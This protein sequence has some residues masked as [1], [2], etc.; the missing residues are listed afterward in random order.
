MGEPNKFKVLMDIKSY[1]DKNKEDLH[2]CKLKLWEQWQLSIMMNIMVKVEVIDQIKIN[3]IPIYKEIW[4]WRDMQ[5]NMVR[6]A[7]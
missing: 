2:Q 5:H 7:Q 6:E 4:T 1:M 3:L